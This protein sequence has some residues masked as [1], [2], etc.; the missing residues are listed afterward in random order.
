M[1]PRLLVQLLAEIC[2]F[3]VKCFLF[4]YK[5]SS[6]EA[7]CQPSNLRG[8]AKVFNKC[9]LRSLKRDVFQEALSI[10]SAP[11]NAGIC[12]RCISEDIQSPFAYLIKTADL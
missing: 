7:H 12:L 11:W 1:D 4:G 2:V 6:T 10:L 9:N 5:W 3:S 8:K